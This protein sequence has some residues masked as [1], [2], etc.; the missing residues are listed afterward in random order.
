V[1]ERRFEP[2]REWREG[3]TVIAFVLLTK[4]EVRQDKSG[5]DYLDLE[6]ADETGSMIGKAWSDSKALQR[7]FS[8]HDF[9]KVKGQVRAFRDQLQFNLD[10][11]RAVVEEDRADGFDETKL[12][13][14][15]RED[16]DDLW[17]R[18]ERLLA[19]L[20]RPVLRR[21]GDE[22]I[23]V[24]GER[25]RT[26]PAA[27][28]IH[29]AYRGGLLEHTVSMAELAHLVAGHYPELDRDLLL[30][31]VLFHDL[32]KILEL[33]AMPANDYTLEGRM[34][35]HVV[36]GRDL[37]RE[38][39]AAIPGFPADLQLQ[40][41]H[42]VLSHQGTREFGAVAEPMTPE[43]QALHFIDDLDSK[44][45]QLR[46]ARAKGP[47]LQWHHTFRRYIYFLPT[48]EAPEPPSAPEPPETP[49]VARPEGAESAD[50]PVEIPTQTSLL[51]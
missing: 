16:I 20:E 6:L 4:K 47:A 51:P 10:D 43:A 38:R 28:S 24:W 12:V 40:L 3:D 18:L 11:C 35:G 17:A 50:E 34:V 41:E 9:V 14:S 39:C 1:T 21:L 30:L 32:G 45:N 25:L 36:I 15:T 19:S 44:M 13:P 26:H 31:G 23:A 46:Q 7:T 49:A 2:I 48:E 42:L 33:G 5:R 22:T 37:L 27:K 8:T 29:H